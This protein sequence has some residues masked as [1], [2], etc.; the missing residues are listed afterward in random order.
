MSADPKLACGCWV[1]D[2]DAGGKGRVLEQGIHEPHAAELVDQGKMAL[3]CLHRPPE[4]SGITGPDAIGL[5]AELGPETLP[6][7]IAGEQQSTLHRKAEAPTG[8]HQ[9][10]AV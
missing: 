8:I 4:G 9:P 1:G 6:L 5:P 7:T 3:G 10:E 2:L